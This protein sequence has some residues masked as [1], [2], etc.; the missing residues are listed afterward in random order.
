MNNMTFIMAAIG[1]AIG[2]GNFWRFPYLCYKWGGG[3]FFVPYLGS[4]FTLGIPM[5]ILEFGLGQL[6]QRGDIGVFRNIHPRLA[7]VGAASVLSSYCIT[8]YYNCIIAWALIYLV[9]AFI[10]PLPWSS[11]YADPTTGA[12]KDS[13]GLCATIPIT[14]EF[15]YKDILHI[16]NDD[17]TPYDTK[18]V[19]GQGS[20]AQW[21]VMISTVVVWLCVFFCV[22]KG[23]KSSS[24]VVWVTVP[25]PCVFIFIMVLNGLTL[26]NAD[27]G[28]RMYL[29]GEQVEIDFGPDGKLNTTH[30]D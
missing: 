8:L 20:T 25:L 22:Y 13:T 12:Y 17:C 14:Q 28:I 7:G 18:T 30:T 16:Y 1:S 6:F 24:Y 11:V 15:F 21:Q 2:L 29:L 9:A 27:Q 3:L 4:L 26:P 23:V 10:N 19:M 5:M